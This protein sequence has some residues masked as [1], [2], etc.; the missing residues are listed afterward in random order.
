MTEVGRVVLEM[1][2][3][4]FEDLLCVLGH[5]HEDEREDAHREHCQADAQAIVEEL[6]AAKRQTDE[7]RQA[8]DRAQRECLGVAHRKVCIW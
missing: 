4:R 1:S 8:G 2:H 7:D 3:S 6:H 5:V